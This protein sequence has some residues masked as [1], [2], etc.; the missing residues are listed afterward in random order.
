MDTSSTP[1]FLG[2]DAVNA[3][4]VNLGGTANAA[5]ASSSA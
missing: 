4:G 1:T 5:T 3:F 2:L